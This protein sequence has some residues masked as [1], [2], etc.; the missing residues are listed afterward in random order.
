MFVEPLSEFVTISDDPQVRTVR[1]KRQD[2]STL[3]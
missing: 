3:G 1:E 2:G